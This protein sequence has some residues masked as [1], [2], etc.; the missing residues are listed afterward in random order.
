MPPEDDDDE[1]Y[2]A[3]LLE[4]KGPE[5]LTKALSSLGLDPA[6]FKEAMERPPSSP[7]PGGDGLAEFFRGEL[8]EAKAENKKL[9]EKIES[10]LDVLTPEQRTLLK[11]PPKEKEGD[12]PALKPGVPSPNNPL[13]DPLKPKR[14]MFKRL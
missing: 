14:S 13:A 5:W 11:S 6:K 9:R 2:F 3:T 12:P 8:G 7:S 10:L 1:T 4:K